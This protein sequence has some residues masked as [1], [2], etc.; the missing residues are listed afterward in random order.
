MSWAARKVL[1]AARSG[2][3]LR[4]LRRV[5]VAPSRDA[6]VAWRCCSTERGG[7]IAPHS[8]S[9][10]TDPA[11]TG[12]R[13][14]PT[15][16]PERGA[17]GPSMTSAMPAKAGPSSSITGVEVST[18]IRRRAAKH[19]RRPSQLA[20]EP[21]GDGPGRHRLYTWGPGR[22]VQPGRETPSCCRQGRRAG[23]LRWAPAA[24][25]H[26][27]CLVALAGQPGRFVDFSAPGNS[28]AGP[29]LGCTAA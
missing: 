21:Q 24:E 28:M 27:H 22:M 23:L 15:H 19:P 18:S 5:A 9:M 17:A 7:I 12:G 10:R 16:D 2:G 3:W 20:N 11:I 8:L 13:T 29:D 26:Y 6:G 25:G 14:G 1:G 4:S